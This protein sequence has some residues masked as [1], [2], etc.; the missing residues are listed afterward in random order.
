MMLYGAAFTSGA[1]YHMIV[2][3]R[4]VIVPDEIVNRTRADIFLLVE[5]RCCIPH[6]CI[7]RMGNWSYLHANL[8]PMYQLPMYKLPMHML[9]MYMLPVYMHILQVCVA[10]SKFAK[11][12][13][14]PHETTQWNGRGIGCECFCWT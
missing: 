1:Q 14:E 4:V 8:L 13:N 9:P 12:A 5:A 3:S 10:P 2:S 7:R 6:S 11:Y